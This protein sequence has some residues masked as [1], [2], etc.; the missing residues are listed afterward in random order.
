MFRTFAPAVAM[1]GVIALAAAPI[2]AF[3]AQAADM[4]APTYTKAPAMSP[5]LS[6]WTGFYIGANG[7]Y[8]WEST[9]AT[10]SPGDPNTARVFQGLTNVPPATTSL[11]KK[12]GLGGI[13]LGDNWQLNE[14]VVAGI[15]TDFDWSDVKGN[16]SAPTTIAFGATPATFDASQKIEW[17]GTLRARLGYLPTD[18]LLLYATGGLAYGKVDESTDVVLPPGVSNSTGNFGFG[19]ACGPFYGNTTCFSGA[20]SRTSAGWTAG[21]GVEYAFARNVSLKFEYLYVNLGGDVVVSRA[22]NFSTLMP[23]VMNASF[24]DAA[25]GLARIGLNYRF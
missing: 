16:G 7:G 1:A 12:G 20:Q 11:D 14:R 6:N 15:E 5:P 22:V 8:G 24:G 4:A 25:F 3:G 13:Q 21:G 23:S 17:F 2:M 18:N 19:Y 9:D 10:E